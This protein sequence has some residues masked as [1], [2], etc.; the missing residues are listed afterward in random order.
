MIAPSLRLATMLAFVTTDAVVA[1]DDLDRLASE[2]LRP[3]FEGLTIDG[4][5]S[6]NDTVLLFASGAAGGEAVAPG[7]PAWGGLAGALGAVAA[8]LVEQLA[9]DGEGAEHVL[10]VEV[11]GA[12]SADDARRAARAIADSL[13]VKTAAFGRDPNPGRLLQAIGASG[14]AFRPGRVDVRLGGVP[15]VASGAIHPGFAD[16]GIDAARAALQARYVEIGVRLG[17]GPGTSRCL[18]VD[19]SHDYVRLNAEYTT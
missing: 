11:T 4:C 15:V 14:A 3:A 18:G 7:T 19:L 17:D 12:V 13:L 10:V 6:T 5:A 8:S 9:D 16:G 2:V 1:P